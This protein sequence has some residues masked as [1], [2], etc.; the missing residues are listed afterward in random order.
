[1]A[2]CCM[3]VVTNMSVYHPGDVR[4]KA[5]ASKKAVP[6]RDSRANPVDDQLDPL[7]ICPFIHSM[8]HT[9]L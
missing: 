1:M 3:S 8:D 5:Q 7:S 4:C 6:A 2:I 9:E